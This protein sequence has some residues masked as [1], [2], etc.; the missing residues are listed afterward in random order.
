MNKTRLSAVGLAAAIAL[1]FL[2]RAAVV[3]TTFTLEEV[4][5]V[6]RKEINLFLIPAKKKLR[7]TEKAEELLANFSSTVSDQIM[8][9]AN[10]GMLARPEV[11]ALLDQPGPFLLTTCKPMRELKAGSPLLF[12]DLS[13]VPTNVLQDLVKAYMK[14]VEGERPAEQEIW[15]PDWK[16]QLVVT[17][18]NVAATGSLPRWRQADA[19]RILPA[20]GRGVCALVLCRNHESGMRSVRELTPA[21]VRRV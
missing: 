1:V 8:V 10:R 5:S 18:L 14:R 9:L 16:R 17:S 13:S 19:R 15:T 7:D 6:P 4:R 12:Y 21:F 3:G 11:L 20:G 2:F